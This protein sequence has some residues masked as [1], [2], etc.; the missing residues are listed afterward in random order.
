MLAR[1]GACGVAAS[2]RFRLANDPATSVMLQALDRPPCESEIAL[3]ECPPMT[4]EHKP[5]IYYV[6]V[7]VLKYRSFAEAK[8]EAAEKIAA[9]IK[10]SKELH[11]SGALVMAGAF[12]DKPDEPLST[13]GV[14]TSRQAAEEYVKGDPFY[15]DGSMTKWTIR[16]WA[17]MFAA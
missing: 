10:R 5:P 11:S 6:V 8:T 12:L 13:M 2:P 7:C 9:H 1:P 17:N 3:G 4:N 16:E 14:L 15:L